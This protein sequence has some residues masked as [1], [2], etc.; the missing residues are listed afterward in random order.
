[1]RKYVATGLVAII[2]ALV[3]LWL[4]TV[5]INFITAVIGAYTIWNVLVALLVAL[6]GIYGL[7]F[8]LVHSKWV[9]K[10]RNWLEDQIVERTPLV[11]TVYHFA[12]Q[13]TSQAIEQKRYEHVVRVWPFGKNNTGMIGF[14]TDEATSTVFVPSSPNPLS[15]QTYVGAK[16]ERL[17]HWTY[18][19][20]LK[21]DMSVGMVQKSLPTKTKGE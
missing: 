15:G 11:K 5:F 14:L 8:A 20:V 10:G 2:P 21:F 13:F 16:Y 19:D 6:A 1:M 7:G 9:R 17:P 12:K 3:V 18:D 4:I